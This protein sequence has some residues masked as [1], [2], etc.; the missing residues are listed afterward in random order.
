LD[1]IVWAVNSRDQGILKRRAE[2][3]SGINGRSPPLNLIDLTIMI[4][5]VIDCGKSVS[6]WEEHSKLHIA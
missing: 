4:I 6:K 3:N 1:E 2:R 5:Q